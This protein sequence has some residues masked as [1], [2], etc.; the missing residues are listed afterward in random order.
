MIRILL[1]VTISCVIIISA[2]SPRTEVTAEM[3]TEKVTLP[4][5]TGAWSRSE[6]PKIVTAATIFDYMNGGGELYL[7]Y[8]FER[9]EV[10]EYSASQQEPV[11][12]EVYYMQTS[13]DAFGLLSLDWGGE[14]VD[15]PTSPFKTGNTSMATDSRALYG[16]GLLRL[17]A[18]KIYSRILAHEETQAS[19]QAVLSLGRSLAAGRERSP[20]PALIKTLS[21][22]V[23]AKWE[24]RRD[25]I[26]FFRSHLVFNSLYYLSHQNILKLDLSAEAVTAPYESA[27]SPNKMLRIQYLVV[28]YTSVEKAEQGRQSFHSGYLVDHQKPESDG[29]GS[30]TG[31]YEIEDGWVGYRQQGLCLAVVFQCPDQETAALFLDQLNCPL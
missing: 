29:Q 26:G 4:K 28:K 21:R 31:I 24:I 7:A 9:L 6:S 14:R 22:K 13:E 8:Q 30:Y 15:L 25:R 10:I 16:A 5:K 19:K 12:V 20:E 27:V 1:L 2:I 18:G 11:T 23:A 17:A 3:M